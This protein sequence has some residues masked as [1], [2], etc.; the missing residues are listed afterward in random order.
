MRSARKLGSDRDLRV[1]LARRHARQVFTLLAQMG[2][3]ED[4]KDP[5]IDYSPAVVA[6]CGIGSTPIG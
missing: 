6:R 1:E 2:E 3:F 4:K 5:D